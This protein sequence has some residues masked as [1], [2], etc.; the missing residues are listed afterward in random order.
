MTAAILISGYLR[1]YEDT[2]N[3]VKTELL[4]RFEKVDVY[5]HITKNENVEDKYFNLINED[6]DIKK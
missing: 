3:F 4:Q 5:I 1:S 2:I 6:E